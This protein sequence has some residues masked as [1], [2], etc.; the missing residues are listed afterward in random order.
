MTRDASR[1]R[2]ASV[3]ETV[4]FRGA[5]VGM[6]GSDRDYTRNGGVRESDAPEPLLGGG[7][8]PYCL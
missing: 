7:T 3:H 8:W 6:A 2:S 5:R 1:S 4:R